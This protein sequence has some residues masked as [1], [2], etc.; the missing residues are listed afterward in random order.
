MSYGALFNSVGS[1]SQMSLITDGFRPIC[2]KS[3]GIQ[4]ATAVSEQ[5]LYGMSGKAYTFQIP[6]SGDEDVWYYM[7]SSGAAPLGNNAVKNGDTFVTAISLVDTIQYVKTTRTNSEI[8]YTGS[9]SYGM[10]IFSA[11]QKRV[12]DSRMPLISFNAFSPFTLAT[13]IAEIDAALAPHSNGSWNFLKVYGTSRIK[14]PPA[15]GET[16]GGP[17]AVSRNSVTGELQFEYIPLEMMS[18]TGY[19]YPSLP[20]I[21]T[22]LV[23]EYAS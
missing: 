18:S 6:I 2:V 21:V 11:D 7:P 15:P 3:T 19:H 17:S 9:T 10:A 1:V 20:P 16:A 12:Y 5:N 14:W 22:A 8:S 4:T 13:S 23:S